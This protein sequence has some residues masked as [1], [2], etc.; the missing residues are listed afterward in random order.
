MTDHAGDFSGLVRRHELS[1]QPIPLPDKILISRHASGLNASCKCI[2]ILRGLARQHPCALAFSYD[3]AA[4]RVPLLPRVMSA[5]PCLD[6]LYFPL[7]RNAAAHSNAEAIIQTPRRLCRR[8]VTADNADVGCFYG[9]EAK[10]VTY[11]ES[12][13]RAGFRDLSE[14]SVTKIEGKHFWK[15]EEGARRPS[16]QMWRLTDVKTDMH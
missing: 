16:E 7:A 4:R 13:A 1:G 10:F 12:C 5:N 15:R 11:W 3:T 14:F 8:E 2:S 6:N 9:R